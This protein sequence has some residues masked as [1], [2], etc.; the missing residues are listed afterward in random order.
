MKG[1]T[2]I[3]RTNDILIGMEDIVIIY[4]Y[5]YMSED[6]F[7]T[8]DNG[9][10]KLEIRMNEDGYF[11]AK[12]LNFP[13]LPDLDYTDIMNIPNM[14]GIIEQL[15]ETSPI[16]FPNSF[17]NRWEEIKSITLMNVVQNKMKKKN[18]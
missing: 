12:N 2:R 9:M 6:N 11:H 18:R 1:G 8:I 16:E 17:K 5:L 15:K 10:A 13:D 3:L 14:L 7:I 4:Q